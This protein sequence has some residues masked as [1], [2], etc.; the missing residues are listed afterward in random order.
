MCKIKPNRTEF[1][2]TRKILKFFMEFVR[3]LHPV[4]KTIIH[5]KTIN[6][7]ST[8]R[9][10]R[11]ILLPVLLAGSAIA[12]SIAAVK[13]DRISISQTDLTAGNGNSEIN[14]KVVEAGEEHPLI[15]ATLTLFTSSGSELTTVVTDMKGNF[16][17]PGLAPGS[18]HL[19]V[20]KSGYKPWVRKGIPADE[21][22]ATWVVV[23]L[24][25]ETRPAPSEAEIQDQVKTIIGV[26]APKDKALSNK[27]SA[28]EYS[29]APVAGCAISNEYYVQEFNTESYDRI[30]ENSFKDVLGNPLSTFSIDVDRASYSNVRRFL[31]NSTLPYKDAVRI[32]ELINY[33]DYDY[34]QP[35]N[36]DPFS[37]NMDMG[38]CPWNTDHKLVLIGIKGKEVKTDQ[39][40][41]SNLVFLI[42]VSGSMSDG[43]KLPLLKQAF[44]ILVDNLRPADRVAMVVYAGAAGVVLESTPGNEKQVILS[45]LGNLEAG[46]S[47][48]GGAGISL[49]YRIAKQNFIPSGNNRVI[50]ATDG[51]FNIGASSDAEMERLIEEKRREGVFLT[52]LGFGMGNYKDS[53]MEKIADAG[54]GNYAYIDNILEAKK[55]FGTELWGTLF[56]IAK[57]VKVQVEFN[58]GKVKAYRLIGYENRMLNKEDFNDDRKDAGDIGSGHTV[59][60][61][62][63]IVPAGSQEQMPAVDPLEYQ[64]SLVMG[65]PN[66]M[67]VKLRYKNPDDTVSR[68]II[69]R[70]KESDL[71]HPG[72][73][74]NLVFASAVAEF[75]MLLRDSE[76]KGNASWGQ[77]IALATEGKGKDVYGY[78]QD[79][80]RMAEAAALLSKRPEV[81]TTEDRR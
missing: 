6:M 41:P 36:G 20:A 44:R 58:P 51:D 72:V 24:K 40:P 18:Y 46:G 52:V 59:T 34:P 80:I 66:M 76:N 49:A 64:S 21:N 27:R 1:F 74:A 47:T 54:N 56:T 78:R 29:A 48:A 4:F 57:D 23:K 65:G 60:A 15:G 8:G 67:T 22:K 9:I 69:N 3:L 35:V 2:P 5:K 71:K 30:N 77:V 68:L 32:E 70:V 16:S 43:N 26:Q 53:K 37:V 55:M 63:E 13:S 10:T 79:F 17:F 61:L 50:L 28:L 31:N 11:A 33:F 38:D 42:D 25:A 62:Y 7:K 19:S 12:I 45:A 14:G 75:G 39:V 73:S 81:S